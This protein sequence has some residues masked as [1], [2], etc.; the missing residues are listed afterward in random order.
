MSGLAWPGVCRGR[1]TLADVDNSS[2]CA[3]GKWGIAPMMMDN[4][5]W[6]WIA[7]GFVVLLLLVVMLSN[8][9]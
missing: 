6:L 4:A 9:D 8:V 5:N 1:P 2:C 3:R 7:I